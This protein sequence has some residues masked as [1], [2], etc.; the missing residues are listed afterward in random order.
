MVKPLLVLLGMQ[1]FTLIWVLVI[2]NFSLLEQSR[3]DDLE[4]LFNVIM[5]MCRG[6]LPWQGLRAKTKKEKYDKIME[7]KIYYL[8]NKICENHPGII[9]L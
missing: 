5:Y 3:R 6:D 1:V 8:P 2:V 7:K 4:A 9:L